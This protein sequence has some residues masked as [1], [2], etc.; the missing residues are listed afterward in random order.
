MGLG[1]TR[2]SPGQGSN[3]ERSGQTVE[4]AR[5]RINLQIHGGIANDS[6]HLSRVERVCRKLSVLHRWLRQ[7][8]LGSSL[9][10]LRW[11]NWIRAARIHLARSSKRAIR[12][13]TAVLGLR[14]CKRKIDALSS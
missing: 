5:R 14:V 13:E 8:F 3:Q 6:Q 9:D 2:N 10:V 1:D 7:A 4:R 12:F 11:R